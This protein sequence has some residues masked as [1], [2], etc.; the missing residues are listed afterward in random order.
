MNRINREGRDES[1]CQWEEGWDLNI[2]YLTI[3]LIT[4]HSQQY[5]HSQL[6]QVLIQS[7]DLAFLVSPESKSITF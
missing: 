2:Q 6:C 1:S 7:R 4:L 5:L 3:H